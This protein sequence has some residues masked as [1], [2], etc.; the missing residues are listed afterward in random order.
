MDFTSTEWGALCD[1]VRMLESRFEVTWISTV[2]IL[3]SLQVISNCI[4]GVIVFS[5]LN[6]IAVDRRFESWSGKIK[7]NKIVICCFSTK[8]ASLK[9]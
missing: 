2:Y 3:L 4:G 1:L 8:H 9:S 5:V 7:D 6:S